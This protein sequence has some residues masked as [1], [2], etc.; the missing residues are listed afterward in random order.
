MKILNIGCGTKTATHPDVV[1]IDWSIYLWIRKNPLLYGLALVMLGSDRRDRLK[2]MPTN[3]QVHDLRKGI[4]FPENSVDAVYHSHFFEHL[5]REHT[6]VFLKEVYRVLKPGGLQ[7]IVVPDWEKL[8]RDYLAHLDRC[9]DG[10]EAKRHDTY[11]SEMIEQMVRR[12]SY[13]TSCQKPWRRKLEN[14]LLG[15]AR[16]RGETHQWMY[17]RVN[18][19]CVLSEAGYQNITVQQYNTSHLDG[20]NGYGLDLDA[21]GNE[22]KPGSLYIEAFK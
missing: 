20:W 1:N 6:P 10:D 19:G 14:F 8:S 4:P 3:I 21:S 9:N 22:Y 18:L 5:D 15:D 16:K 12:E 7:R 2:A 13:G 11:V 17:D